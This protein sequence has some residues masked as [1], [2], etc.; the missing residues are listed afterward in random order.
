MAFFS[1]VQSSAFRKPRASDSF[2]SPSCLSPSPRWQIHYSGSYH[3]KLWTRL[4]IYRQR[5]DDDVDDDDIASGVAVFRGTVT[6][7]S[8]LPV[9]YGPASLL[10][11]RILMASS[12]RQRYCHLLPCA[13]L[14]RKLR[15]SKIQNASDASDGKE[16][17]T[18]LRATVTVNTKIHSYIL[19]AILFPFYFGYNQPQ[20]FKISDEILYFIL[21]YWSLYVKNWIQ[22]FLDSKLLQFILFFSLRIT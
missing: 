12:F 14:Y 8:F 7:D 17:A 13:L 21:F 6:S 10:L 20:S 18:R 4:Y 15:Q 2:C 22:I 19:Y 9:D 11:L 3:D 1:S 16:F 5:D